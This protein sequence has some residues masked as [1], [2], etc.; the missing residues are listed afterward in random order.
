MDLLLNR[1]GIKTAWHLSLKEEYKKLP[2]SIKRICKLTFLY[3]I[4]WAICLP[5]IPLF[6]ESILGELKYVGL[7]TALVPILGILFALPMGVLADNLSKKIMIRLTLLFYLPFGFIFLTLKNLFD[8]I[9]FRIYH[10]SIATSLWIGLESYQRGHAPKYRE[11]HSASLYSMALNLALVIGPIIGSILFI[12]LGFNIFYSISIFSLITFLYTWRL[13]D[14]DR[15]TNIRDGVYKLLRKKNFLKREVK[16][17]W[18]N[19]SIKKIH[20]FAMGLRFCLAFFQMLLPIF[21]RR[22]GASYFQI[23]IIFSLFY[24]PLL[25]GPYFSLLARKKNIFRTFLILGGCTFILL[26]FSNKTSI[27]L[28]LTII[29]ALCFAGITPFI[30]GR[31]TSYIKRHRVGETTGITL[32]ITNIAAALGPLIGGLFADLYSIK[33]IFL[34][35]GLILFSLFLMTLFKFYSRA[36]FQEDEIIPVVQDKLARKLID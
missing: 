4:G 10:G 17:W 7:V 28:L 34:I 1:K 30:D 23:G 15:K 29:L 18:K 27:I 13:P 3:Y 2:K 14:H 6:F 35:G 25:F 9:L 20:T 5:F 12:Y 31:I 21:L 32:I 24:L 33:F 19:K 11:I 16:Y 8:L 36:L 26:F 22:Y